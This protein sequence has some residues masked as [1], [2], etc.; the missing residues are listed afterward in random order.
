MLLLDPPDQHVA[1]R[2]WHLTRQGYYARD[3][4]VDGRK[5]KVLMH[6]EL[7]GLEYGDRRQVDHING[8]KTDNRRCN[9]RV[10]SDAENQRNVGMVGN[11]TSGCK[12]VSLY[13]RDGTWEAHCGLGGKKYTAGRYA[14]KLEA[15][16]V[17][18]RLRMRLHGAFANHGGW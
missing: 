17:A 16:M 18:A 10:V 14:C 13:K 7:C 11:N 5:I 6:R 4:R 3:A 2:A 12:G 15:F 1:G 9:L 8:R